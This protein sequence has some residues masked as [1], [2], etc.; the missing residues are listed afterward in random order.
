MPSLLFWP[1]SIGKE[2]WMMLTI[3]LVCYGAARM[4]A[5]KPWGVPLF[6]LGLTGTAMVRP[7]I[8]L[9]AIVAVFGAYL[10]RRSPKKSLLSFPAKILVLCVLAG[11]TAVVLDQTSTF[12]GVQSIDT[13][14]A[15]QVLDHTTLQTSQG[16]SQADVSR[17]TSPTGIAQAVVAVIFRPWPFEAHNLQELLAAAEGAFLLGM[18]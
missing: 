13:Q 17:P 6:A 7:H 15:Q 11:G 10:L 5:A 4:L 3:G 8:S 2:S 1:S 9:I 18:I 12:F 14:S 16:G